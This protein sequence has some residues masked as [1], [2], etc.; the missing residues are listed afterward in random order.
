MHLRK[1]T[2]WKSERVFTVPRV[3]VERELDVP[4]DFERRITLLVLSDPAVQIGVD[5]LPES[6]DARDAY[7]PEP[8]RDL[9]IQFTIKATQ[10]ISARAADKMAGLSVVIEYL[11]PEAI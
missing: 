8:P 1:K 11:A 6:I 10:F 4:E 2:E 7:W 5:E 3:I 9:A